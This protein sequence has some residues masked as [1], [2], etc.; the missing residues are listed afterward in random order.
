MNTGIRPTSDA[1]A[2]LL[3]ALVALVM[4]ARNAGLQPTTTSIEA[5]MRSGDR[6]AMV[7]RL[8]SDPAIART[9]AMRTIMRVPPYLGR[10]VDLWL[11]S[12]PVARGP[13][14]LR[15][16]DPAT[17]DCL[18]VDG[19]PSRPRPR[20]P[21]TTVGRVSGSAGLRRARRDGKFG[22]SGTGM[23]IAGETCRTG[24]TAGLAE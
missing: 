21:L 18:G 16:W 14:R 17:A 4:D 13:T 9:V 2:E 8:G 22:V 24:C 7:D 11:W 5:W 23:M 10:P 1:D 20:Y 3:R 15:A 12:Q 6:R 19:S